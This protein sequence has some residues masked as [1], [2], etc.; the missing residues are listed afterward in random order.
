M[1]R[2]ERL[3]LHDGEPLIYSVDVLPAEH[4]RDPED[5]DWRGSLFTAPASGLQPV[6][7]VATICAAHLPPTA[8]TMCGT[9]L[10]LPWLLMVQ[11]NLL[12]DGSPIIYSHD[13]HRGDRFSFD[14]LRRADHE[15][16]Q[17]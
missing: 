11:V 10:A 9:D 5:T 3:R 16:S 4:A 17:Q 13:Y 2:L 7:A 15:A 14:L 6:T 8:A 12:A 1:F